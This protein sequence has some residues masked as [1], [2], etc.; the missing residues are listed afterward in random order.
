MLVVSNIAHS[1]FHGLTSLTPQGCQ[2]YLEANLRL[3]CECG[4]FMGVGVYEAYIWVIL[5]ALRS[6][7]LP[8]P[9]A[10]YPCTYNLHLQL[11]STINNNN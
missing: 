9:A 3:I 11:T 8:T 1:L 7:F 5:K 10:R 6:L 2:P 4:P